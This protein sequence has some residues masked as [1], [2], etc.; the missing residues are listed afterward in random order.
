MR[1]RLPKL[2]AIFLAAGM[3]LMTSGFRHLA[4]DRI[5]LHMES[6]NL[7]RGKR[8]DVVAGMYYSARDG[9]LLT[10]YLSPVRQVM[11]TNN[12]GELSVYDEEENTVYREQGMQ[13]STENN[14]I[15]FF[16]NGQ[17]QDLGL[18]QMGFSLM[19]TSFIDGLVRTS[20]FPPAEMYHLFNR[21]ELVHENHLPIYAGYYDAGRHLVKKVYYTN[22]REFPELVLPLT[23]T[24]FNYLPGGDSIVNRLIFSDVRINQ[25]A[26]SPWFQ[27]TIPDDARILR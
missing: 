16:L 2:T 6:Q 19:E 4:V 17:L 1:H 23:I 27:F 18:R 20:W 22:Y 24:E 8:V 25:Q 5:M 21:I 10:H 15:Y 12:K 14:L 3:F 11:V 13:Y 26:V 9:R 7:Q